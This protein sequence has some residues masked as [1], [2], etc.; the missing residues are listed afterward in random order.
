MPSVLN[1]R[2][3]SILKLTALDAGHSVVYVAYRISDI[4]PCAVG[5]AQKSQNFL[6]AELQ[7]PNTSGINAAKFQRKIMTATPSKCRFMFALKQFGS[8]TE[9]RL[10]TEGCL[11]LR[12]NSVVIEL[13][14]SADGRSPITNLLYGATFRPRA[15]FR[16]ITNN[17]TSE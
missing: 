6:R 13:N 15:T 7:V 2:Y 5:V 1:K 9:G 3:E 17:S 10:R 14:I 4:V 16:P 11:L 12:S 8:R